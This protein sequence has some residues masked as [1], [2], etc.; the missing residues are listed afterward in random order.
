MDRDGEMAG[1]ERACQPGGVG[2]I[3]LGG[4][5]ADGEAVAHQHDVGGARLGDRPPA[6]GRPQ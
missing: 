1:G 4:V 5:L 2:A 3:E 6:S